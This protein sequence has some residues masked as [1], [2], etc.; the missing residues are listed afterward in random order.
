MA[1]SMGT[2][3]ASNLPTNL[4][5]SHTTPEILA[6]AFDAECVRPPLGR[7]VRN[8]NVDDAR[9]SVSTSVSQQPYHWVAPAAT[10]LEEELDL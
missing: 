9:S 5:F 3:G 1:S 4:I 6:F 7:E 2:Q 10:G 8:N